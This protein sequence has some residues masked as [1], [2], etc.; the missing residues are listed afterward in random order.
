MPCCA[1]LQEVLVE[2]SSP[3]IAVIA[4]D[5][6]FG[7]SLARTLSTRP[8]LSVLALPPSEDAS[9]IVGPLTDARD[10][11]AVVH[12]CDAATE[13]SGPIATL[14]AD[15]WDAGCEQVL[16]RSL[17]T[18]QAAHAVFGNRDGGRIVVVT[19]TAG[20]S[21]AARAVPLVAAL[22]GTRAMAK[23]AARQWGALGI[24]V[25]CI[26][27]PLAQL[28]PPHATLTRFLP[29]PPLVRDDTADDAARAIIFLT[30]PDADGITGATLLVDGGSVMAP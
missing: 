24:T 19:A 18:L 6:G 17:T 13:R 12:V 7:A 1:E 2:H 28:A 15:G 22:E 20:F 30:G 21:G 26:S 10:V 4:D 9:T 3:T 11:T 25:N 23:S 27:V 5:R 29:P 16:R 8:E 14:D